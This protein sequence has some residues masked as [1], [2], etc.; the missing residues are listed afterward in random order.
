MEQDVKLVKIGS[1]ALSVEIS[2][3]GAEI[4]SVKHYGNERLWQGDPAFWTGRAPILFPVCGS[5]RNGKC[6][7]EG[8]E[9]TFKQHGFARRMNFK[10]EETT[11]DSAVFSLKSNDETKVSYPFDFTLYVNYKVTESTLKVSYRIVNEGKSTMWASI[12]SHETYALDMPI[13]DYDVLFDKDEKFLSRIVVDGGLVCK[14]YDDFGSG[15][16]LP[17]SDELFKRNTAV[18]IG[19]NSRKVTL[20]KKGK[21]VASLKFDAE[22]LLIWTM[23]GARY[24]CLEPWLNY[25]DEDDTDGDILKK[26]GVVVIAPGESFLNEHEIEYF[27]D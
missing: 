4:Q 21:P 7:F 18:F 23:K 3:L 6:F 16:V 19:I 20:R 22:N 2:S 11:E 14:D 12:G 1:P 9:Y 17:V 5:L 26:P 15:R 24:I 13:D 25:P 10:V 27:A 8:K